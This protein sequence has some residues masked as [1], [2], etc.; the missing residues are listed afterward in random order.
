[1]AQ[2]SLEKSDNTPAVST[3]GKKSMDDIRA[4]LEAMKNLKDSPETIT[5]KKNL[6]R[7]M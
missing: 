7:D 2:R 1:M 5:E 4:R 6:M 3:T